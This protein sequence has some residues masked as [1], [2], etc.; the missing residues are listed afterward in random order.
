M[1]LSSLTFVAVYIAALVLAFVRHPGFGL[2]SYLWVFYN[3][4]RSR[5]WGPELPEVRWSL[6][7]AVV[8]FI[9][10]LFRQ[11]STVQSPPSDDR[12]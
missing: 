8:T 4:P 9:A 1:S 7:A 2:F 5:W 6:I 10:V 12:L 3:Y 11:S